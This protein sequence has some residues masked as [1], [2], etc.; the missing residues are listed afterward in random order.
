MSARP[1][2]FL[3]S[4][5]LLACTPA[6]AR[7]DAGVHDA[8]PGHDVGLAID[9]F[10]PGHDAGPGVD[11]FTPP[12]DAGRD[13]PVVTSDAFVAGDAGHDAAVVLADAG[14]DAAVVGTDA[15]H[16]AAVV[17]TCAL[18]TLV[19]SE[20]RT[21]GAGGASDEF[22]ELFNPTAAA[23]VLDNT[24]KIEA[25]S[26]TTGTYTV[27]WT[28]TGTSI[29][30]HGHFLIAGTGYTQ[31]PV[32]DAAL[33]SGV[34]DASSVRL[35]HGTTNVDAICFGFDAASMAAYDATYTCEGTPVSNLPHDNS[36]SATSNSDASLDRLP[37]GGA[38]D[39]TD[40][41]NNATDFAPLAPA[42]PQASS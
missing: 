26:H 11:A 28:G 1:L 42:A 33:S 23:V 6:R 10:V 9:A 30:A 20:I 24:W 7:N 22:V 21:R 18:T 2:V 32:M 25:R 5:L 12:V 41:G 3:G 40:T 15:G 17:G 34:T 36:T 29:P 13:A 4:I 14:H 8:G 16:D 35:V 39:C 27:R 37:A 38:S 19:I 31:A